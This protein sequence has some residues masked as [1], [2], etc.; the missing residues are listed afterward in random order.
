M[1]Y[2]NTSANYNLALV[3]GAHP[4][5]NIYRYDSIDDLDEVEDAGYFNNKDDNLKL[6]I[7]DMIFASQ[8]SAEPY[9]AGNTL[10]ATKAF[11][12]TNVIADDA[13]ASAG[14][15]NIAEILISTSGALSSG[16]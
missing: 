13:A 12:V 3:A 5:N 10:S 1:A 9:A 11:Q 2:D 6:A 7:G 14:A 15:V 16:D 8:W 4:G